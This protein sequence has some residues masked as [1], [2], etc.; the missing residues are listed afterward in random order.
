MW[1]GNVIEMATKENGP[2]QEDWSAR[3]SPIEVLQQ[4]SIEAVRMGREAWGSRTDNS[5]ASQPGPGHR[6]TRS[7]SVT[8]YERTSNFQRLKCH[9]QRAFHLGGRYARDDSQ[10]SSFDPEILANQKRQWYQLNSKP[11][12]S[13]PTRNL[14]ISL[15]VGII[16]FFLFIC[17]I[18]CS[19]YSL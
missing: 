7:E 12:V 5:E 19:R 9:M 3:P 16:P 17:I 15:V 18:C 6:R 14:S 4:L 8:S 11:M 1:H 2:S 13:T 10:Y